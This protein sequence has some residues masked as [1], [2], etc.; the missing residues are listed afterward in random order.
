MPGLPLSHLHYPTKRIGQSA[1]LNPGDGVVQL[2]RE[3]SRFATA[4]F[5]HLA[6]ILQSPDRGDDRGSAAAECFDQLAFVMG[7]KDFVDAQTPFFSLHLPRTKQLQ[8]GE[9]SSARCCGLVEPCS[10]RGGTK[11]PC[12]RHPVSFHALKD[13]LPV[14]EHNACR[15]QLQRAVGSSAG[16]VPAVFYAVVPNEDVVGK[17]FPN[18]SSEALGFCFGVVFSIAISTDRHSFSCSLFLYIF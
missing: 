2:L 7:L 12:D 9:C 15:I 17:T 13:C 8:D 5:Y 18:P 3:I 16:I 1:C 10:S 14:M 11:A 4:D 6:F